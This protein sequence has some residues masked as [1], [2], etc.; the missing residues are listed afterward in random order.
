MGDCPV[1]PSLVHLPKLDVLSWREFNMD[2]GSMR[3]S[4]G[5]MMRSV[6]GALAFLFLTLPWVSLSAGKTPQ[7]P[8]V[9]VSTRLVQIGVIVRDK[10]GTVPDLTKDDFTIFDRGKRRDISIFTPEWVAAPART[11]QPL[12][13]NTFSDLPRYQN[14][15]PRSVTIVMLDNLNTLYGSTPESQYESTPF[16]V[17]DHAL[18]RARAHLLEFLKTLDPR[19]R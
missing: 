17:E 18:Q 8:R 3:S 16:W 15:P 14:A 6:L 11:T 12:P 7:L 9:H 19:D 4:D 10:N 1:T 2:K 5:T 13:A